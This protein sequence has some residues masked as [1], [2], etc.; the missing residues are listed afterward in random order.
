[1]FAQTGL[2]TFVSLGTGTDPNLAR[3]Y[4]NTISLD[5]I[6]ICIVD[7]FIRSCELASRLADGLEVAPLYP[8]GH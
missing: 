8:I 7:A 3:E 4:N 5:C 6:Y 1:M 2:E